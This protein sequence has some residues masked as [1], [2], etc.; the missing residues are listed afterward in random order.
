MS[1]ERRPLASPALKTVLRRRGGL[2]GSDPTVLEFG[3]FFHGAQVEYRTWQSGGFELMST[4]IVGQ[5]AVNG[6]ARANVGHLT[7]APGRL[8]ASL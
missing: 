6:A 5:I 8:C 7:S 4:N 1:L 2:A 3:F